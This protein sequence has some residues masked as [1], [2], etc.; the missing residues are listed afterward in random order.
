MMID[1]EMTEIEMIEI[2]T[3]DVITETGT[4]VTMMSDEKPVTEDVRNVTTPTSE[5]TIV[6]TMSTEDVRTES[7]ATV[8]MINDAIEMMIV[9]ILGTTTGEST[10]VI[11]MMISDEMSETDEREMRM[12]DE[13]SETEETEMMIDDVT[14][15]MTLTDDVKTVTGE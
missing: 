14:E 7:V 2:K 6:M 11:E 13:M 9:V 10:G 3:K 12:L 8:T 4:I 15:M 5:E 1:D